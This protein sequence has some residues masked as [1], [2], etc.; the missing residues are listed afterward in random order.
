MKKEEKVRCGLL[1]AHVTF[2]SFLLQIVNFREF[3]F[4]FLL[5]NCNNQDLTPD[6]LYFL[7]FLGQS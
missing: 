1:E 6:N 5:C 3:F 4:F 2:I 7:L